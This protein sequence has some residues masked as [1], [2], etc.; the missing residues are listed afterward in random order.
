MFGTTSTTKALPCFYCKQIRGVDEHSSWPYN[1]V[2]GVDDD[3][4]KL[5]KP[6]VEVRYTI[7]KKKNNYFI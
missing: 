4:I 6:F 1:V 3:C 5:F 2:L 7:K